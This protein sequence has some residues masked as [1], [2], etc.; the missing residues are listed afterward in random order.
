MLDNALDL[1]AYPCDVSRRAALEYRPLALGVAGFSDM[2]RQMGLDA[3]S[4]ASVE[5]A[6][7]SMETV[8]YHAIVASN[9]ACASQWR[10]SGL[11]RLKMETR[12]G[13][14]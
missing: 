6:D 10:V 14:P 8:S 1:S 12:F 11:C 7:R 13:A 5:W 4:P 3:A 2:L 9:R